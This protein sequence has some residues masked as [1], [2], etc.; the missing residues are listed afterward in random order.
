MS[1]F[2]PDPLSVGYRAVTNRAARS[3]LSLYTPVRYQNEMKIQK[4]TA[5]SHKEGALTPRCPC[6][7]IAG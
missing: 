5:L 3:P 7:V 4:R 2:R 1:F 6:G